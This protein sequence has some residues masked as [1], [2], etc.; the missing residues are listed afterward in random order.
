MN[1][2]IKPNAC[3]CKDGEWYD[4]EDNTIPEICSMFVECSASF[5]DNCCH[6]KECHMELENE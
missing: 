5:C 6:D 3:K 1:N 2:I 4:L